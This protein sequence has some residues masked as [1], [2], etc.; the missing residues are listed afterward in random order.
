VC[1][2]SPVAAERGRKKKKREEG[3]GSVFHIF[4]GRL[5]PRVEKKEHEEERKKRKE[6]D[7]RMPTTGLYQIFHITASSGC[8][9]GKKGESPREKKRKKK[10]SHHPSLRSLALLKRRGEGDTDRREKKALAICST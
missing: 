2:D 10:K 1:G 6:A 9:V 4:V 8:D 7:R 3:G 5:A